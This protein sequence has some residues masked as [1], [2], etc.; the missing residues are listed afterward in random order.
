MDAFTPQQTVELCSRIGTKKAHMRLDKLFI[1]SCMAG[2]LLG[3]G[4]LFP[5]Y[6]TSTFPLAWHTN[7]I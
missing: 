1:N 6:T 7:T 4:Y 2:P 3:F 5:N